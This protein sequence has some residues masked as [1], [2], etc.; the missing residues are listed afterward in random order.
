MGDYILQTILN[1]AH[2][3]VIRYQFKDMILAVLAGCTILIMLTSQ[4]IVSHGEEAEHERVIAHGG[5]DYKGYET[6]NSVEALT[7]SIENGYKIIE[8]DMDLSSDNR[9]IML[10][11][12]DRTAKHYYNTDFPKKL[13]KSQFE[14][15]SVFGKLEVLTLDRL[16]EILQKNPD[17]RIVTDVKDDNLE[18][19][20]VLSKKYP[21][22]M[23]RF[24]PQIYDLDQWDKVKNLGFQDIIL[25]LYAMADPDGA[26]II[27]FAGNHKLYAVTMPDYMAEKGLCKELAQRGIVVYVHPVD[28]YEDALKFMAQGAYGIYSGSLLPEEFTGIE[29]DYYLMSAVSGSSAGKLTDERIGNLKELKLHGLKPGDDVYYSLDDSVKN[30]ADLDLEGLKPGK[31]KLTV[32]IFNAGQL[33]GSL[34]YFLSKDK[35][36]LRVLHKKYE[37][38][39]D[40]IKPEKDFQSVMESSGVSDEIRNILDRSLI[41]SDR[42]ATFYSNG[43][44]ENYMNGDEL[45][46]PRKGSFGKLL[47][48]LG[49]TVQRLGASSVSMGR[50]RDISVVYN[51]K[52]TMIMADT[53]IVREGF[54]ITRLNYPVI[55]YL[56]KAM[57]GGEYYRCITGRNFIEQDGLIIILPKGENP[58]AGLARRL[59]EAAGKLYQN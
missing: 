43:N 13:S 58:D 38:R 16:V 17:I 46:T 19:L 18:L 15:L 52:K 8:L 41:A 35:N 36:N 5:G 34:D 7:Q 54:M 51:D 10:H 57:A 29:K 24:I 4:T 21:G 59:L 12:W 31:H 1:S 44:S 39:L 42:A 48:P 6:S 28:H 11:D 45:L 47:L 23:D 55:L 2:K 20:S 9:I 37:Y 49:T 33:K 40:E 53:G 14:K 26:Q 56:N 3:A 27:S 50:N 30:T 22:L 32:K 25:T